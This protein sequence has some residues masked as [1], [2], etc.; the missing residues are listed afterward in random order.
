MADYMFFYRFAFI[1]T[2]TGSMLIY[3]PKIM[4]QCVE[5][6]SI[7]EPGSLGSTDV[8]TPVEVMGR[9]PKSVAEVVAAHKML[10]K[11]MFHAVS[12]YGDNSVVGLDVTNGKKFKT[13]S[14]SSDEPELFSDHS[15]HGASSFF[16][17]V[18]STLVVADMGNKRIVRLARGASELEVV[19]VL[20]HT[21]LRVSPGPTAD[22]IVYFH[23]ATGDEPFRSAIF[24]KTIRNGTLVPDRDLVKYFG[25]FVP[26]QIAARHPE[27]KPIVGP[28]DVVVDVAF[29][30]SFEDVKVA[31][32]TYDTRFPQ[33]QHLKVG[34]YYI[35]YYA[36]T[37]NPGMW[38]V[39]T[40][41]DL[42]HLTNDYH[43]TCRGKIAPLVNFPV[44]RDGVFMV[45]VAN[46]VRSTLSFFKAE[47]HLL[48]NELMTVAVAS[49]LRDW[50]LVNNPLISDVM[51]AVAQSTI[52]R[53]DLVVEN[54]QDVSEKDNQ[55]YKTMRKSLRGVTLPEAPRPHTQDE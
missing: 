29:D 48:L 12:I 36:Y 20:E 4:E 16:V 17:D 44:V 2:D 6:Y 43:R 55:N 24:L 34:V 32:V 38:S 23:S 35:I 50:P 13:P 14:T 42:P 22:D 21:P 7:N 45:S 54:I 19:T 27:G 26:Q 40:R 10:Q 3:V 18:D 9:C 15:L 53:N 5:K 52:D 49:V 8:P 37:S 51:G 31:V 25:Q 30:N 28:A 46:N 1:K 33:G 11:N 41:F 47:Y 39:L